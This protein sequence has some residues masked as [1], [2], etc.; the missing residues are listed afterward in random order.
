MDPSLG[1]TQLILEEC[2]RN[3]LTLEQTSYVL[4]TAYWETARTMKPVKEAYWLSEGWRKNN[5]RYY[6]WY[7]RGYVQ[8]TW[9]DNYK[10]AG[11]KLNLDLTTNPDSV[12]EPEVSAK[13]MVVGMLEGWFT[14]KRLSQ[15]INSDTVDYVNARRIVNGTDKAREIAEIAVKYENLLEREKPKTFWEK[16]K[17]RWKF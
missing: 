17:K 3:G 13:I 8:L 10:R 15:Y 9:E 7:G 1:D 2:E 16:L 12:M 6:P 5:L 14:G 11:R 4:A